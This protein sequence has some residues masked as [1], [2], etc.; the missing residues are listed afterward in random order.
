MIH[1]AMSRPYTY[2]L[3]AALLLV[4][5]VAGQSFGATDTDRMSSLLPLGQTWSWSLDQKTW[6][7]GLAPLGY[8]DSYLRTAIS[9]PGHKPRRAFFKNTFLLQSPESVSQLFFDLQV[10][11]GCIVTLNGTELIRYNMPQGVLTRDSLAIAVTPS[12]REQQILSHSI[13][14]GWLRPG[15][16]T[17]EAQVYQCSSQSSD[18]AFDLSVRISRKAEAQPATDTA[19][20]AFGVIADCQY[21]DIQ[22]KGLRRYALS[23]HKLAGCVEAFNQMDLEYVVHLGDFIDRDFESFD[24]VGP[25]FDR[26]TASKYH[27]LGNH[28]FSVADPLK[29]EV[30]AKLGM[31]A[32]YYDFEVDGWRHIILDGNDVSFHA[33]PEGS[34]E[35][36]QAAAYY[37]QNKITSPKWNGAIGPEQ[38]VWLRSVLQ[39]AQQA[40][41]NVLLFCHFPVYPRNS[42]NL[43][44][45][46][47]VLA[48]LEE[49][50]CVKA[51]MNG[52][53]HH[54]GYAEKRGVHYLTFKGMVDTEKTS[55][56][57]VRLSDERIDVTGYG[58]EKNR[59]LPIRST[60]QE[61][62]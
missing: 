37:Q 2:L 33:Y 10:D 48:L 5:I 58:R 45:D 23:E 44:N 3:Q 50:S 25:I 46:Q 36:Q 43:W 34:K 28:D 9:S 56:A 40:R 39:K 4:A 38:L 8:G 54:G 6:A 42:H 20:F 59:S 51:Y 11:D 1:P 18:L 16:N 24:V 41:E 27:V 26:L 35:A 62:P 22:S 55:Y 47:Q 13:D 61:S 53:N 60:L 31:P 14:P 30:P 15:S 57:V 17:L 52:H 29:K 12:D 7:D 21:C 32:K 19:G 49:F